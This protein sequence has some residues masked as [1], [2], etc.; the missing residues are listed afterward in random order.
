M[1]DKFDGCG[2]IFRRV[3]YGETV[4]VSAD[5]EGLRD[6][7]EWTLFHRIEILE[8]KQCPRQL[9]ALGQMAGKMALL[10]PFDVTIR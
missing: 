7:N 3:L 8:E 9:P 2:V 10:P 1:R 4:A 6:L 5:P